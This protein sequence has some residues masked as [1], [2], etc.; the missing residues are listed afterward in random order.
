MKIAGV[1]K[2]F[3]CLRQPLFYDLIRKNNSKVCAALVQI[4]VNHNGIDLWGDVEDRLTTDNLANT[5][6]VRS[7]GNYARDTCCKHTWPTEMPTEW[8]GVKQ[9]SAEWGPALAGGI[10]STRLVSLSLQ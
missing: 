3:V 8:L 5:F 7:A 9:P 2:L 10:G 1:A 4:S 6:C